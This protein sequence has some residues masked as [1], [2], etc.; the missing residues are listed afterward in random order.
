MSY[1]LNKT[2]GTLL[3]DL[4]DGV[5]DT[6]STDLTLVGKNYTGYGESFNEN[7]IKLLENFANPNS[8]VNPLKGQL[9]FDSSEDKL[10][11]FDGTQFVT[12]AGS[13][14]T[15]ELPQNPQVGDT[16]LKLSTQQ[17][18]VYTGNTDDSFTQEAGSGWALIG[19]EYTFLQQRSGMLVDSILDETNRARTVLRLVVGGVTTGIVSNLEFTPN[20]TERDRIQPL[21]TSSNPS[22]RIFQG[23]NLYN[24]TGFV[25]RGTASR[26]LAL[27]SVT[28]EELLVSD[29]VR[30][31][32]VNEIMTG[33][34]AIRNSG[35]LTVG[36]S[37]NTKFIVDNGFVI[38][39]TRQDEDLRIKINT[40]ASQLSETEALTLK[41]ASKRFGVFQPN[42]QYTLDVTGDMRVTGNFVIEGDATNI[43][44][45]NLQ[46]EDKNIELGKP[47]DNLTN[48][49]TAIDGGGIILKST[50]GDKTLLWS[51]STTSWTSSEN[52]D[53]TVGNV[54]KIDG[55]EIL[56]NTTLAASVTSALGITQVGTLSTLDVDNIRIDNNEISR[57]NGSGISIDA[58]VSPTIDVNN[59][60]IL[61]VDSPL[62]D[63][64][65][66]NKV[67]VDQ[68]VQTEPIVFG[69]DITGWT[70][71]DIANAQLISLL[72]QLYPPST[73]V[74]GKEARIATFWYEPQPV[75]GIDV[76]AQ[77]TK[78]TVAVNATAGGSVTVLQDVGLPSNLTGAIAPVV[79]RE[80]RIF[81]IALGAWQLQP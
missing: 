39:N 34:L 25:Y 74:N 69:M 33:T 56:S 57:L 59:A 64:E 35:G 76:D 54:Y 46:V 47:Q 10:K 15:D 48:D 55:S 41:S 61:N 9:W 6:E 43:D 36:A 7:F 63:A 28:G 73:F 72:D 77:S 66:A 18:Y 58:G 65:A 81:E 1:K 31:D 22:G 17:F 37:Q 30:K 16:W 80:V 60:R 79:Q 70:N 67:Y 42:P 45:T 75:T 50:E 21:V 4:I 78:S 14:V 13:F 24:P 19:P 29:F 26:A 49:D 11:V 32:G 5:I 38:Q 62:A 40:S 8:P 3:T 12:A 23:F 71:P 51:D 27:E 53:I 44:V 52:I 68:T 20:V 2:D